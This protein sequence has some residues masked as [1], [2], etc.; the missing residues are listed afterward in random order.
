MARRILFRASAV[1]LG[2]VVGV[3]SALLM[4]R[5]GAMIG[6]V[7]N[8]QWFGSSAVGSTEADPYTRALVARI[9]L[10]GLNRNETIYFTTMKDSAGRPYDGRCTYRISGGALPARWWAVTLYAPDNFLAQN[11]D[12]HP[13]IDATSIQTAPDGSWSARIAPTQDGAEDWISSRN[14]DAFSLSVR[15]YNPSEK[16]ASDMRNVR[17]PVIERVSCEGEK[18]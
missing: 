6:R 10:L 13:S 17:L 5:N 15:L 12:N 3:G 4:I 14:A 11:G 8:G 2:I 7:D 1:V 9:G 16:A 18:A